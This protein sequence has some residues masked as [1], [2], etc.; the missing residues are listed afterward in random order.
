MSTVWAGSTKRCPPPLCKG[1]GLLGMLKAVEYIGK[2]GVGVTAPAFYRADD[3]KVYVVKRLTNRVGNRVLI[4]ELFAAAFG[5]ATGLIFPPAAPIDLS[6]FLRP[7]AAPVHFASA[8]VPNCRYAD[9]SNIVQADNLR[10]MAGVILFDHLF[11]NA[12]RTNNRKNLLLSRMEEGARLYAIDN[13]HLF[14]TGRWT[15]EK[16]EALAERSQLYANFLYGVLLR[17]YLC[18]DDFAPYL[19]RLRA[20]T[21]AEIDAMLAAIPDGWFDEEGLRDA[22]RRFT[23]RR[24]EKLDE[25]YRL[26]RQMLPAASD[27]AEAESK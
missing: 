7:G 6:A 22:L 12:D 19:A 14:K 27:E 25:V 9:R 1:G 21:P 10:E 16:L 26:L 15:I 3:T 4:S 23:L 11:H 18:T 24:L 8:Y 13:S 17:R 20:L 2:V 5:R